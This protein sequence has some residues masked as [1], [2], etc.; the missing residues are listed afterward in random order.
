MNSN[1]PRIA[2]LGVA[3]LHVLFMLGE[4]FKWEEPFILGLVL[5]SWSRVGLA[6]ENMRFV[7]YVVHNAG[8]YNGIVA[9]GLFA[10]LSLGRSALP[11]QTA[12][13]AGGIVAGVFGTFTLAPATVVQAIVGAVAL[14]VVLRSRA[15]PSPNPS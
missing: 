15:H 13:L 12:L 11:V 7:S 8:I 14:A 1:G 6:G 4:L 3:V 9:A 2:V 5:Q 10:S